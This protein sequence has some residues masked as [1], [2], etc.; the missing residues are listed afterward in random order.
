[1][2]NDVLS[3]LGIGEFDECVYRVLLHQDDR[4]VSGVA[5][6][7]GAGPSR[8]RH[9]ITRLADLGLVRRVARGRFQPV[10]PGTALT[11]L[12]NRRRLEAEVAF[13]QVQ[14][15][16]EELNQEYRTGQIRT[17]AGSLVQVLSGREAVN[18][19]VDEL[20]R[21]LNSHWWALD[22]PPYLEWANGEQG[23]TETE[24]EFT[25]ALIERGVDVRTVY[26]PDS[27]EQRPGRFHTLIELAALGEQARILP[28]LPF[29]LRILDRRVALLPLVGGVYDSLAVVHASGLLDALIELFEAYWQRA[30]PLI[31]GPAPTEDEPAEDDL[32]ILR[33]LRAGLKDQAIARQLGVSPRTATRRIAGIIARLGA[34]SRFQAGVEATA[35]GWV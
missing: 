26:C 25:L 22:R 35:R 7:L 34:T 8:V 20:T 5:A 12:L 29:K 27:M 24:M 10:G 16:V 33:M 31:P 3:P 6:F 13:S 19:T 23:S 32:L 15:A 18:R 4:S 30:V 17:D 21:S 14:A 9:A 1:M 28:S 11:G 2:G